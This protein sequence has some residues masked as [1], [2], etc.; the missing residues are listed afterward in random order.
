MS[1]FEDERYSVCVVHADY[2]GERTYYKYFRIADFMPQESP[3]ELIPA[4]VQEHAASLEE[5]QA[6]PDHLYNPSAAYNHESRESD[7]YLFQ[8]RRDPKDWGK[9]LTRSFYDDVS[10][11]AFKEAREVILL[12]DKKGE[13][14]LRDALAEGIPFEGRTTSVFY[15]VYDNEDGRRPAVRCERRDFSFSDGKIRL[16]YAI[17]NTK[18]T[19]LSAPR[20]W[21][22]DCDIIKSPHALTSYRKVYARLEEPEVDGGVLLRPLNYYAADYVKWFIRKESIQVSKS[23]RRA[24]PQIIDAAFL[25]PDALEAYLKAGASEEEVMGLRKAI[26]RIVMEKDDP[27]RELFR[28]ALLEDEGFYR[29]C[30]EQ[31]MRS[32]DPLLEERNN[33]LATAKANIE[34]AQNTLSGL[35]QAI[36]DLNSEKQ[37]LENDMATLSANLDQTRTE[38]EAALSE[39]QSNI[40]LKL[41]L[42]AVALQPVAMNRPELPVKEGCSCDFVESDSDFKD[43]LADNLKKLGITSVV[44]NPSAEREGLTVGIAG[45]L[46]A[47]KFLALPQ[48]VARQVADSI[49]I[50]ISG[51]SA[52]KVIVPADFRDV[53]S[54]L[55]EISGEDAVVIVD[56]VIDAVNEGVLFALL[57][58]DVT[59]IVVLPFMSHASAL[60]I[61]K[62]AWGKMYLP[63]VEGLL[64]YSRSIKG[65][66]LQRMTSEPEFPM[67]SVDD[68][69]KEAGNLGEELEQLGLAAEHFLLAAAVFCAVEDL[70]D[71]DLL[72]RFVAQHLLMCSRC[73][74]SAYKSAAEWS[75]EDL[76][77]I[78][79]AKKLGIHG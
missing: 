65:A 62:E 79:L 76:G 18:E 27:N 6:N 7:F 64:F 43:I 38:Q 54:V 39:I 23:D 60:L 14:G 3:D 73:D 69:L 49:S 29:E 72:E 20:V 52:K 68:A 63:N 77:L 28:K 78:E 66:K 51:R 58:E 35:R 33:E 41:G 5:A 46:A 26:A 53:S 37:L 74:E 47:T 31:V 42:R 24:V 16:R 2:H 12:K 10:L 32:R 45:A 75:E 59:P 19:V 22:N 25:R 4:I 9:Q 1:N 17:S 44:G 15:I 71:E 70:A 8:W 56:G 61:A 30:V 13:Q 21:F 36:D 67:V 34:S 11:R 48:A 50:A 55:D 57:S 40:A